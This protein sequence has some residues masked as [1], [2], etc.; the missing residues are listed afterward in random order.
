MSCCT[1]RRPFGVRVMVL[2][3]PSRVSRTL[4]ISPRVLRRET[5][6]AIVERSSETRAPSVRWSRFGSLY[7]ALS[8][9]NWGEV[10]VCETSSSHSWFIT[11]TARRSRWPG[12]CIRSSGGCVSGG[13]FFTL[14][15]H[16]PVTHRQQ[17]QPEAFLDGA[18]QTS[19]QDERK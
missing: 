13:S 12:C 16:H 8:A 9:A 17:A 6:S 10:I 14:H 15:L 1:S 18:P 19:R 11:Y 5:T 4:R 3:R 2:R 7:S